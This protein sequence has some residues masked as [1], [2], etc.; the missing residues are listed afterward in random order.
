M[1]KSSR[2]YINA[3]LSG[4]SRN[5]RVLN[6]F[7]D[8]GEVDLTKKEKFPDTLDDVVVASDKTVALDDD[9]AQYVNRVSQ[10]SIVESGQANILQ[11]LPS[12]KGKK[13]KEP[14]EREDALDIDFLL[15]EHPAELEL[16]R[17]Q[18]DRSLV[19]LKDTFTD[20]MVVSEIHTLEGYQL[21]DDRDMLYFKHLYEDD[22]VPDDRISKMPHYQDIL[23]YAQTL[24]DAPNWYN[25]L[26]QM[27]V[28][29]EG[30]SFPT[31]EVINR[32]Y[33]QQFLRAPT[34]NDPFERP[35]GSENCE[36]LR[37]SSRLLEKYPHM[38]KQGLERGFR[39]R[40]LLLPDLYIRV[41]DAKKQPDGKRLAQRILPRMPQHCFL[42]HLHLTNRA[43]WLRLNK[44]HHR[45]QLP[46]GQESSAAASRDATMIIHRF[47]VP[48]NVSGEY[49]LHDM[50]LGDN[51]PLG[52]IG[53][54]P[55]YNV[56]NY[57]P[58]MDSSGRCAWKEDDK[59]VF[60]RPEQ[61]LQ[62]ITP[63]ETSITSTRSGHTTLHP[64]RTMSHK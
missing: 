28:N 4:E 36:S 31:L 13:E 48:I 6:S 9:I 53:P 52:I 37:L 51:E 23:K 44:N 57:T 34:A 47:V 26:A 25:Q 33:I 17:V 15:E 35:C 7:A 63:Q 20:D 27:V 2:A 29:N 16:E 60:R 11:D 41:L 64:Q 61:Q 46:Q 39:C 1:S 32:Q 21:R 14:S 58:Y 59:L 19:E 49:N 12:L 55:R 8:K 3:M 5:R 30:T 62:R 24:A 45:D 22:G 43:Y 10:V 40:E 18:P 42:C 50:L 56:N 54:F 38:R